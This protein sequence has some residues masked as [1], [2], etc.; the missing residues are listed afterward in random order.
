MRELIS[1]LLARFGYTRELDGWYTVVFDW[2]H[3]HN[4]HFVAPSAQV[5]ADNTEAALF[6]AYREVWDQHAG[7]IKDIPEGA[8]YDEFEAMELWL[9]VAVLEGFAAPATV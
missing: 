2:A 6:K 7:T 1:R 8:E 4:S 3:P 5:Q 9:H